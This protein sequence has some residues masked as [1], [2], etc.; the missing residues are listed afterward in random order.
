MDS[1]QHDPK[2]IKKSITE[3]NNFDTIIGSR[4]LKGSKNYKS[5]LKVGLDYF[6]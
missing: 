1:M 5:T 2:N 4:F 3:M 6:E